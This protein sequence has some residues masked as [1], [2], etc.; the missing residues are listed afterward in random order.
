MKCSNVYLEYLMAGMFCSLQLQWRWERLRVWWLVQFSLTCAR[1]IHRIKVI[2]LSIIYQ[3]NNC[4]IIDYIVPFLIGCGA[5][6][7]EFV[8]NNLHEDAVAE[9]LNKHGF[10][11]S[12]TCFHFSYSICWAR[13]ADV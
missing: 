1:I 2:D 6:I 9:Y 5:Q 11:I 12:R 8:W 4:P 13:H 3:L 7:C 10:L